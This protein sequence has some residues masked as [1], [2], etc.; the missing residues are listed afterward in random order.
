MA[1]LGRGLVAKL[2]VARSNHLAI[3]GANRHVLVERVDDGGLGQRVAN[4]TNQLVPEMERVLDVDYIRLDC[5]EK[6]AEVFCVEVLVRD[7]A[8]DVV[9]LVAVGVQEVLIRM[10]VHR[11]DEGSF[12]GSSACAH[13]WPAL[14]EKHRFDF[15]QG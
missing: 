14:G 12:M 4:L 6:R 7:G 3:T 1:A 5:G 10:A 9:E 11:S 15:W 13:W 8:V 2:V